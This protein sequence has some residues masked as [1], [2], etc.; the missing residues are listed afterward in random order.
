MNQRTGKTHLAGIGGSESVP[1][2]SLLR[3]IN[4][5]QEQLEQS[6]EHDS[7]LRFELLADFFRN[8]WNPKGPLVFKAKDIGL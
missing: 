5:A 8:H 2:R 4:D 1:I 7:A 6:N 3:Y